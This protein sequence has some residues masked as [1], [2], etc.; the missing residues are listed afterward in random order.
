MLVLKHLNDWN[1]DELEFQVRANI[2]YRLF[3]QVGDEK[4]PREEDLENSADTGLGGDRIAAQPSGE[5]R[6]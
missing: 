4:V 3:S 1:Y 5:T 2:V 6:S